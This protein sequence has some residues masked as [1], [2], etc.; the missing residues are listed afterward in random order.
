MP[1]SWFSRNRFDLLPYPST[2]YNHNYLGRTGTIM[3]LDL[4]QKTL[5]AGESADMH[6]IVKELRKYRHGSVT[7][8]IQVCLLLLS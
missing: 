8:D 2:L 3:G 6:E 4:C 7:T 1:C 5:Q